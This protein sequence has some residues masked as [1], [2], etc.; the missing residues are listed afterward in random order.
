MP[1]S[2]VSDASETSAA[3]ARARALTD[4][5]N[6]TSMRCRPFIRSTHNP[7]LRPSVAVLRLNETTNKTTNKTAG[8]TLN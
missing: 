5:T 2:E 6:R 4:K 3:M 7:Y 1:A 8:G